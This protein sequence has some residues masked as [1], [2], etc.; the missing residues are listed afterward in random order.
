MLGLVLALCLTATG[1]YDFVVILKD[2]DSG[3]RVAVNLNSD[4]MAWLAD[5]LEKDDLI[6]TPEYSLNEVTLSG[7]MMY[8]GWPYYAW[9][10][11]YDTGYRKNQAVTIYTT[12]DPQTLRETAEKEKITYILFEDGMTFEEYECREDVIADT[13]PLVYQSD[14]GRIRIYGTEQ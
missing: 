9:S 1:I 6:L 12:Q 11:G 14:D 10:A 7:A 4:V 13:Y 8:L 3:H 2:N 5:H